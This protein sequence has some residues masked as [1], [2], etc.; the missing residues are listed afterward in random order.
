MKA[1]ANR[2]SRRF[3]EPIGSAGLMVAMIALVLGLVGGAYA[4]KKYVITSTSQIKPSVLKKLKGQ[5]G[6]AG[7]QGAPGAQGG[8]GAAGANGKDGAAGATGQNGTS[9]TTTSFTGEKGSCKAGGITVKSASP[10]VNVCNGETGFTDVLPSGKTETG[11]WA[12]GQI[13]EIAGY[14]G[15][16]NAVAV[17]LSFSIPL[18]GELEAEQV[19][20]IQANGLE[21]NELFEEIEPTDCLGSAVEPTAEPGHMCV[22]TDELENGISYFAGLINPGTGEVG[23]STAGM[24][25]RVFAQ[26]D[27]LKGHGTWAVTAP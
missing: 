11:V 6:P 18:P 3:S 23:A 5:A 26:G 14:P 15:A 24:V 19:H 4:A 22:Y 8:P 25:L 2:K 17:P 1:A 10:D 7:P 20:F 21:L 12:V 13:A 9:A 16:G 27:N